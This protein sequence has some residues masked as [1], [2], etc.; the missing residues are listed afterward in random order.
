MHRRLTWEGHSSTSCSGTSFGTCG[1]CRGTGFR[2][3][4]AWIRNNIFRKIRAFYV[5]NHIWCDKNISWIQISIFR[6]CCSPVFYFCAGR[7]AV[8]KQDL[9]K[10]DAVFPKVFALRSWPTWRSKLGSPMVCFFSM[11]EMWGYFFAHNNM[12]CQTTVE[13]GN[14]HSQTAREHWPVVNVF[15][16][17]KSVHDATR[18]KLFVLVMW[19]VFRS[20]PNSCALKRACPL[21]RKNKLQ[22]PDSTTS[23]SIGSPTHSY[24]SQLFF[25][26][27][28]FS[29]SVPHWKAGSAATH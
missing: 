21:P 17:K 27:H 28:T 16:N 14:L 13:F 9:T 6:C 19:R 10:L 2:L 18:K 29:C 23:L 5:S 26:Q 20:F 25:Y 11:L 8:H 24:F 15:E 1:T 4:L 12:V 22:T 3:F 7:R